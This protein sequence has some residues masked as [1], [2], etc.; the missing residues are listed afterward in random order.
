VAQIN[1]VYEN[2]SSEIDNNHNPQAS[3][4]GCLLR[5]AGHDFMDFR[6]DDKM[7]GGSDGCMNFHDEDNKGL[8]KCIQEF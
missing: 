3:F 8:T 1:S 4:V 7:I 5:F 2:L 6:F